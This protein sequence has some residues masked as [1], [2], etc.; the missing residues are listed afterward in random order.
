[1]N[2]SFFS[3][4][5]FLVFLVLLAACSNQERQPSAQPF[6]SPAAT[7]TL[8]ILA[9]PTPTHLAQVQP[10]VMPNAEALSLWGDKN[11]SVI[12]NRLGKGTTY[13]M[14]LSPDGETI[15]VTGL[16]SVST[17]D[18]DSLEMIWT[19]LL[20]Q[21]PVTTG[22]GGV[23]WSPDGTQLATVS[24]IG[25]TVWDAKTGEQLL[26]LKR[27]QYPEGSVIWTQSGQPAILDFVNGHMIF[28]DLQTGEQLLDFEVGVAS[29]SH[30]LPRKNI[31]A[32]SQGDK[33]ISVWNIRSKQQISPSFKACDGYC[34]NGL[35]LSPDGTRLVTVSPEEQDTFII[36]DVKTGES[37]FTFTGTVPGNHAWTS[38]EWSPDSK[39][40]AVA[41]MNG[42]VNIWDTQTGT[43]FNMLG[44][45]KVLDL[46]WSSDGKSLITLSQYESL[47][48]W[49]IKTS[50]RLRSLN[51]H[52]SWIMDLAWSPD[53]SMLAWSLEDGEILIWDPTSGKTLHAFRDPT[54]WVRNLTWSPD[55]K[56]LASGGNSTIFIWD[57]Q[58]GK[59]L[60]Q[61]SLPTQALFGLV[62]SP[63][64]SMLASASYDGTINL[65]DP[66]TGELLRSF[67]E[68][69]WSTGDLVWSPQGDVLAGNYP[70][71][72]TSRDQITLWNPQTGE[73]V[74]SQPG[75]FNLTWSPFGDIAASV[76]DNGTAYG[77]DDKTLILWDP[78]TGNEL[79]RFNT[80]MFLSNI[81]WSSDGRFLVVG[82]DQ[83]TDRALVVL[84]AQTGEQLHRLQGHY[85]AVTRAAWSPR[86]DQIASCSW[87][88]TVIIW[89]I[90]AP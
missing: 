82:E 8:S 83:D 5:P 88:G 53:G 12:V 29:V 75:I 14:A 39:Y 58:K 67:A 65:W 35:R 23:V 38:M 87:D 4:F 56:Q 36:W 68:K 55:G 54:G 44:V 50:K 11:A 72:E 73:P 69:H 3:R 40:L 19:S 27:D 76:W 6:T 89:E 21:P 85:D 86:G 43:Q 7:P 60:R 52:T 1:M 62:W 74:R 22:R 48:V 15:A 46:A 9:N 63:D 16:L 45:T 57:T 81:S 80:G 49:D 13:A 41:F 47:I 64:G 2:K 34:V 66:A 61:W 18:F 37:L 42:T 59:Q 25:S 32:V 33:G 24:E 31:L 78:R 70:M 77:G 17:Y 28:W 79:R 10:R 20:E 30:W 71:A 51:E 26:I 90:A 84:D